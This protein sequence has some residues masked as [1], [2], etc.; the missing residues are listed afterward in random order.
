ML[1]CSIAR[2]TR[3]LGGVS[4]ALDAHARDCGDRVLGVA[5]HPE[6]H[7]E[8]SIA[9]MWGLP[10]LAWEDV[11]QGTLRLLCEARDVLIPQVDTCQELLDRWNYHLERPVSSPDPLAA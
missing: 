7:G 5:L 1:S 6:D 3:V 11:P 10:V 2:V 4:D 9:E 8:L